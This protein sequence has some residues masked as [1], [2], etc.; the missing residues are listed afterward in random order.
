V[1]ELLWRDFFRFMGAKVGDGL[2]RRYGPVPPRASSS[3]AGSL[4]GWRNPESDGEAAAALARWKAGATGTPLVDA[5]MR[6]LAATGFM[7]N[8][9]RQNVASFLV[10]DLLVD[11]R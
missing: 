1:F 7:S 3:S 2:F 11:W 9:G 8:R 10:H 5:N 6:E 4:P